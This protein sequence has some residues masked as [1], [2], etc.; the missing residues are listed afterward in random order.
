MTISKEDINSLK[1]L[2]GKKF[3]ITGGNGMLG[4][5]FLNQLSKNVENAV[6]YCFDKSQL[7]VSNPES[8][9][10]YLHLN[11]DFI[12]HCAGLVNADACENNIE[13]GKINIVEGTRNVMNFAKKNNSKIFYPQSFLIYNDTGGTINEETKPSPLSIYGNLKLE[14]ENIILNSSLKTLSV[15]M[16]GF[17]GGLEKDNNFVGKI[18]S[19][20]SHLIKNGENSMEIGDRIWQPT[21]TNDL[22]YNSLILLANDKTGKFCMSSHGSCSFF[23]LTKK[24]LEN[25][26]IS[27][28]F[29]IYKISANILAKREIAVRPLSVIMKNDRLIK[30]N[31]D[32][33]RKWEISLQEYLSNPYFKNLF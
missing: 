26:G 31:L 25:L 22:A 33:Q 27:K 17:F 13:E 19:H 5:A 28:K 23:E 16:G 14:A 11:P 29:N 21:D 20:I 1:N 10:K 2:S 32:R 3:M 7:E 18:I 9:N 24:I 30:E 8:F 6:I 12:I 15:H 4:N